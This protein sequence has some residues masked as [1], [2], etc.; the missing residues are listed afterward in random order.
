MKIR[1]LTYNLAMLPAPLGKA[2]EKRA[3]EFINKIIKNPIYD[4]IG[5]QEIF[6]EEIRDYL[7]THLQDH[8][9][10]IIGKSG[11]S[12]PL[13]QDSGL[14]FASKFPILRHRFREFHDKSLLTSDVIAEKGILAT[15]FE[16]GSI[17]NCADI[18]GAATLRIFLT[19][20][21]S[22]E[23][24]IKTREKQLAQLRGLITN[25]LA[26]ETKKKDPGKTYTILLGDFNVIGDYDEEYKKMLE[27]L[28]YPRDLFRENNP[29]MKGFTWN[30][31][32]NLFLQKIHEGDNDMQRLDYIFAYDHIPYSHRHEQHETVKLGKVACLSCAIFKPKLAENTGDLPDSCDLSDHYGIE[33]IIEIPG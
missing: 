16:I 2:K 23:S 15:C 24:E 28:D 8:Y 13:F 5:L 26:Q 30:S 33:A 18:T 6:A 19:H 4:I 11:S 20:L 25:S 22:T 10:H 12:N 32:E 27:L 1:I 29:K 31:Q 3:E 7:T 14:F 17:T 9:P 21:Q